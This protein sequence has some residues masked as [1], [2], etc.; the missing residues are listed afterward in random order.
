LEWGSALSVALKKTITSFN[1]PVPEYVIIRL[2]EKTDRHQNLVTRKLTRSAT[3]TLEE[4][5][6]LLELTGYARIRLFLALLVPS[7]GYMRWRYAIKNSWS[8]PAWYLVRWW[9]IIKDG[10]RSLL[11]MF[12]DPSRSS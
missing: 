8:M 1:T 2:S 7:P 4:R 9:G 6:K 11:L 5:Q 10:L 3:H 12:Q